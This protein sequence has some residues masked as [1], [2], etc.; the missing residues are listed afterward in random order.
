MTSSGCRSRLWLDVH[1]LH[2]RFEGGGNDPG[3]LVVLCS[4]HHRAVHA[5]GL[6]LECGADCRLTVTHRNGGSQRG[7]PRA[8]S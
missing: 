4:G 6:A 5:G 8:A 2:A 7:P 3:N 1:H